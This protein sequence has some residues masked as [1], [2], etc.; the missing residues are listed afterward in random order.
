[1]R[2]SIGYASVDNT[3]CNGM[4][5]ISGFANDPTVTLTDA[6]GN[7]VSSC[8]TA[9]C[10]ASIRITKTSA[11]VATLTALTLQLSDY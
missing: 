10:T 11:P 7:T 9:T 6:N 2:R 5:G 3:L 4:G 8:A 1:M